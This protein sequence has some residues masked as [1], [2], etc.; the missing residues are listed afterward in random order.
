MQKKE[1]VFGTIE[2]VKKLVELTRSY[3]EEIDVVKGRYVVDMKSILGILSLDISQP[4]GVCMH[5]D[6][7]TRA[8][9]FFNKV[10]ETLRG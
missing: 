7:V 5:T 6:D 10:E 1:F 4:A 8:D 2:N 3:A 9:E